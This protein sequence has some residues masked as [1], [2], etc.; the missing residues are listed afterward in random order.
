MIEMSRPVPPPPPRPWKLIRASGIFCSSGIMRRSKSKLFS[1]RS[2]L[3][4]MNSRAWP[5]LTR[6]RMRPTWWVSRWST[7]VAASAAASVCSMVVPGTISMVT[8]VV[9]WSVVG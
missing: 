2:G 4:T 6:S 8:W 3:K 5:S 7:A 1:G 9:S